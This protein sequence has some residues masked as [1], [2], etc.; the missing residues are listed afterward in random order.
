MN[1]PL[2]QMVGN[3]CEVN[4]S[5]DVLR[6]GGPRDVLDLTIELCAELLVSTQKASS[7]QAARP[8]LLAALKD[9]RALTR[10]QQMIEAQGGKYSEKLPLAREHVVNA[11]RPGFVARFDGQS[12]GHCVVEMGGGRRQ[13]GD[14]VDHSVGMEMLQKVGGRVEV[15]QPLV[16]FFYS[17]SPAKTELVAS[18]IASAITIEEAAPPALSL[19][20]NH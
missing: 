3:A 19:I 11:N 20:V 9:G 2:G 16:K 8:M 7:L 18:Q 13:Q 6:A 10:Y 15:G 5:I 1:Q 17:G 4:E 14:P 12:L